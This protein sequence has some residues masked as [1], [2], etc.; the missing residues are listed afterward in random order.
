MAINTVST[1]KDGSSVAC[2]ADRSAH[3][4]L[5]VNG[6]CEPSDAAVWCISASGERAC[7]IT[8]TNATGA[9][10]GTTNFGS[11]STSSLPYGVTPLGSAYLIPLLP[12]T[13][14]V[15]LGNWLYLSSRSEAALCFST[16]GSARTTQ[17]TTLQT[18]TCAADEYM[19]VCHGV[20]KRGLCTA[21]SND[22][23]IH[24]LG[25]FYAVSL[26]GT[27]PT[28]VSTTSQETTC[29]SSSVL[30]APRIAS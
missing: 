13:M 4:S 20:T 21:Y 11:S 10:C 18:R 28:S 7:T 27:P 9:P 29:M 14:T 2:C 3:C 22:A 25:Q 6:V 15:A 17:I 8:Y 16:D 5:S 24:E 30:S 12:A 1:T 26:E 23:T 19:L